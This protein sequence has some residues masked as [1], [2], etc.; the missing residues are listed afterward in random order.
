[1]ITINEITIVKYANSIRSVTKTQIE[2]Y[3]KLIQETLLRDIPS[4]AGKEKD[5]V[6]DWACD[7]IGCE[8]DQE[9]LETIRRI[10]EIEKNKIDWTC[11]YCNKNTYNVDSD[12]LFGVN[13]LACVLESAEHHDEKQI[14]PLHDVEQLRNQMSRMQDYITQLESRLSQL[15]HRYEEPTN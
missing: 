11:K 1:M 7:I 12:Y 6:V 5:G 4:L 9:V 13:H 10:K 3:E 15:E 14:E 2:P 8:T